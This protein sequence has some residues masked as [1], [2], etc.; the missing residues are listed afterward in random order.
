MSLRATY[1][2]A[3]AGQI[4][5]RFLG[6]LDP[7]GYQQKNPKREEERKTR[8]DN[9]LVVLFVLKSYIESTT[10]P[11]ISWSV[12]VRMVGGRPGVSSMLNLQ[13]YV[14]IS[15]LKFL[16]PHYLYSVSLIS[17][18]LV[19]PTSPQNFPTPLSLTLLTAPL[20]FIPARLNNSN[21]ILHLMDGN[22]CGR[23]MRRFCKLP[24]K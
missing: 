11:L 4:W 16:A 15:Y 21:K 8:R 13:I 1:S 10:L 3:H 14:S 12:E 20:P 23:S 6:G 22:S 7:S 19:T 17:P 2:R 9:Y 24:N 18:T 5:P